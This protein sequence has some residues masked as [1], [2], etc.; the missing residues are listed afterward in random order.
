MLTAPLIINHILPKYSGLISTFRVYAFDKPTVLNLYPEGHHELLFQ[1]RGR[2]AQKSVKANEWVVRP[3]NFLGGLHNQSFQVKSLDENA[4]IVSIRFTPLG[5]RSFLPDR[6]NLYK[7]ALVEL[8]NLDIKAE[9]LNWSE[10]SDIAF[11]RQLDRF[12]IQLYR[13]RKKNVVDLVLTELV[14]QHGFSSISSICKRL[15]VSQSYL[16]A[17]FNEQVGMS[18]KE[19]SK[20]LRVNRII[21]LLD[22]NNYDSLTE[23]S[24]R[25][26]YFDQA[27]FIKDFKSV[28]GTSPNKYYK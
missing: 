21:E 24:Y 23:L 1:L 19:Y 10:R 11:I 4:K 12:L 22:S 5:A 20:I 16:R 13:E 26:G 17:Q 2:F 28:T 9:N 25:L 27:H 3:V 8:N 6:L 18:P 15:N 7:N 14:K